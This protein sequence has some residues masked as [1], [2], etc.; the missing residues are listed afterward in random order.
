M[1]RGW[2][3]KKKNLIRLNEVGNADHGPQPSSS[4][5]LYMKQDTKQI[6]NAYVAVCVEPL[7]NIFTGSEKKSCFQ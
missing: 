4:D 5:Q 1:R 7:L 2:N 6:Y 3:E